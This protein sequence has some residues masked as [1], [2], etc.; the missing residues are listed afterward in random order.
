MDS[1]KNQFHLLWEWAKERKKGNSMA[2]R[3]GRARRE[4]SNLLKRNILFAMVQRNDLLQRV[5]FL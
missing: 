5:W 1:I 3:G 4:E 2:F